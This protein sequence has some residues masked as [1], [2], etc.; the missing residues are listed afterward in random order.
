MPGIPEFCNN[1]RKDFERLVVSAALKIRERLFGIFQAVQ[2][3]NGWLAASFPAFVDEALIR[4]L[5]AA[6]IAQQE[7]GH[8]FRSMRRADDAVV[9]VLDQVRQISGV[10]S[11]GV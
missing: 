10:I 11:M 9:A 2:R 6:R 3:L 1:T 7:L 4:L 8:I 5:Y